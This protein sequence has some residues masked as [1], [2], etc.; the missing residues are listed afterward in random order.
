MESSVAYIFGRCC[1]Y[2]QTRLRNSIG[3]EGVRRIG[4][5]Y[6]TARAYC[7]ANGHRQRWIK[8]L[9]PWNYSLRVIR[10]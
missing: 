8:G 7:L 3:P 1:D 9:L 2:S 10:A 6:L 5:L 4:E